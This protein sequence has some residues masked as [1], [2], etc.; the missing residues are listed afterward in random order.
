VNIKADVVRIL[1]QHPNIIGI[2]DSSGNVPQLASFLREAEQGFQLIVGTASAWYPALALGIQAAILAIANTHP[3]ECALVQQY[4]VLG[5]FTKALAIYQALL[6]VNIALTGT[7]GVPGLK[8]AS[9]L[10][11]YT[12]KYVRSP[13]M[14]CTQ[15]EKDEIMHIL[16][17]AEMELSKILQ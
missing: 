10:R 17:T 3:E 5:E 14:D 6:P 9:D 7:Y 16:A 13:L 11:G 1:S 12:G 8:Y 2:K 4:Y 15:K